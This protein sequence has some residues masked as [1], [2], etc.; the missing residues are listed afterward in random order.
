MVWSAGGKYDT[1]WDNNPSWSTASTTCPSTGGSL[2]LGRRPELV[3]RGFDAIMRR[4]ADRCTRGA[5]TRS[6]TSHCPTDRRP[7]RA[8]KGHVPRARVRQLARDDVQL[9]QHAGQAGACDTSV[10]ADVPTYAVFALKGKRSYVA[11]NPDAAARKVT[12]SDGFALEVARVPWREGR[13]SQRAE[14]ATRRR[15]RRSSRRAA[16]DR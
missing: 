2:Y 15:H 7:P 16:P 6:C 9:D 8:G 5:T 14:L 1:W 12:F 10:T 3:K 4:A 13:A 11:Y